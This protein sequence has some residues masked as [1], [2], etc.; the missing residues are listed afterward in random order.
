METSRPR[1][2]R[3]MLDAN[4]LVAGSIWP[5]FPGQV[6]NHAIRGD[7]HLVLTDYVLE[8]SRRHIARL[9]P[10]KLADFEDVLERTNFELSGEPSPS[11]IDENSDLVR[12]LKDVPIVLAAINAKVDFFISQDKDITDTTQPVHEKLKII[13]P[14]TF[15]RE[16]MGWTSEELEQVRDAK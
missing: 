2:L 5:R 15:L 7:F 9:R 16:H 12:D 13:L 3:V 1:K 4:V 14:G 8:E 10:D 11:E 6:L